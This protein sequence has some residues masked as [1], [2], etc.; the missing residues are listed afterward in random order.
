MLTRPRTLGVDA[1]EPQAFP[2]EGGRGA[3][4]AWATALLK[5]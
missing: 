5:E 3:A 4:G 2:T 1:D